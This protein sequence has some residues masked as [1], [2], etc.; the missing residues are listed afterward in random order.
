MKNLSI[1][2]PVYNIEKYIGDNLKSLA[3]LNDYVESVEVHIVNDGSSDK[4][5][6]GQ[7]DTY[8]TYI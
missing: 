3:V 5:G 8:M 4:W 7:T 1:I 6:Q 2:I